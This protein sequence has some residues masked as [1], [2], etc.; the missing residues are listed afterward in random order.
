MSA[1]PVIAIS[2]PD[3]KTI[4]IWLWI[5]KRSATKIFNQLARYRLL[6]LRPSGFAA[7]IAVFGPDARERQVPV[8]LPGGFAILGM[9]IPYYDRVENWQ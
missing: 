2:P 1:G 4:T 6:Q 9:V 5:V 8:N 7:G 3:I